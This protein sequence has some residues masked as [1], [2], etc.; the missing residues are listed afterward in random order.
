MDAVEILLRRGLLDER[1][2][3]MSRDAQKNGASVLDTAIA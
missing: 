2:L 1:Q 3:Q